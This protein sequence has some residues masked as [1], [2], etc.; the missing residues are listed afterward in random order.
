MEVIEKSIF[1]ENGNID[2][3]GL[4]QLLEEERFNYII[5][6][7]LLKQIIG[8]KDFLTRINP[9]FK[10]DEEYIVIDI[11]NIPDNYLDKYGNKIPNMLIRLV[12]TK[13]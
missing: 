5:P 12:N 8:N 9:L 4:L 3:F 2:F 10:S 6:K 13:K 11:E 1:T 7:K